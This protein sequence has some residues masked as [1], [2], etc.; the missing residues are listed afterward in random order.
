[1]QVDTN[2]VCAHMCAHGDM[3]THECAGVCE[4]EVYL[5]GVGDA[6]VSVCGPGGCAHRYMYICTYVYVNCVHLYTT[7]K[8]VPVH[9]PVCVHVLIARMCENVCLHVPDTHAPAR[10]WPPAALSLLWTWW[11]VVHDGLGR[12]GSGL[13]AL[14]CPVESPRL[15]RGRPRRLSS[16]CREVGDGP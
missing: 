12:P 6:C 1:M 15:R 7:H 10:A 13:A 9:I 8:R 3:C 5:Y 2:T 16:L 14:Q 11:W 4:Y